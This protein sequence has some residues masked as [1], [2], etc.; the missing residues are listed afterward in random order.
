M[1]AVYIISR[2]SGTLLFSKEFFSD[3]SQDEGA[4]EP[5]MTP[6]RAFTFSPLRNH[7]ALINN[8]SAPQLYWSLYLNMMDTDVYDDTYYVTNEALVVFAHCPHSILAVGVFEVPMGHLS[9]VV[10]GS[11]RYES[12]DCEDM[13]ALFQ[14]SIYAIDANDDT[15]DEPSNDDRPGIKSAIDDYQLI[16]HADDYVFHASALVRRFGIGFTTAFDKTLQQC[17]TDMKSRFLRFESVLSDMIADWFGQYILRSIALV[18]CPTPAGATQ[19]R[20]QKADPTIPHMHIVQLLVLTCDAQR[21]VAPNLHQADLVAQEPSTALPQETPRGEI[22]LKGQRNTDIVYFS[23]PILTRESPSYRYSIQKTPKRGRTAKR[24]AAP[25][26]HQYTESNGGQSHTYSYRVIKAYLETG[27]C[28]DP[29][30]LSHD[31][32]SCLSDIITAMMATE[33]SIGGNI[34]DGS[35]SLFI[36]F[37]GIKYRLVIFWQDAYRALFTLV[38]KGSSLNGSHIPFW[39]PFLLPPLLEI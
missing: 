38:L 17:N 20:T 22:L 7:N 23:T 27:L 29:E 35:A 4:L 33:Q 30:I 32:Y 28:D 8:M 10:G 13:N 11:H 36:S 2:L 1:Q 6:V 37:S 18:M 39:F 26:P 25:Q 14:T 5:V 12:C 19:N 31:F 15:V 24:V 21:P 34:E 16:E 9:L 3:H